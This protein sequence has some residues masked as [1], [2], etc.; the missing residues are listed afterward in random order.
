MENGGEWERKERQE[1]G[2]ERREGEEKVQVIVKDEK[3]QGD[4]G[5]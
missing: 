5:E 1:K 3:R 2:K 4:V